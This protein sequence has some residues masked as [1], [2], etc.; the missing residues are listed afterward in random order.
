MGGLIDLQGARDV[1]EMVAMLA[2][3]EDVLRERP[4]ISAITSW[5]VSPLTFDPEVSDILTFWCEQGMPVA[6]S[7]APMA[8]SS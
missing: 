2:G 8:G 6:L 1:F 5:M 4:F 3:G 7:S